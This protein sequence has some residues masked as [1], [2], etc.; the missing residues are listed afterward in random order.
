[1]I[2]EIKVKILTMDRKKQVLSRKIKTINGIN[3]QWYN[4]EMKDLKIEKFSEW[5][6]QQNGDDREEKESVSLKTDQ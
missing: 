2:Y 5:V 6:Q 4:W 1:M 3:Q